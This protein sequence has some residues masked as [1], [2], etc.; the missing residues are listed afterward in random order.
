MCEVADMLAI[1][2]V[3]V[4]SILKDIVNVCQI[5]A[6]FLPHTPHSCFV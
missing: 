4:Q 2:F 3:S 5:T 6:K 1:S